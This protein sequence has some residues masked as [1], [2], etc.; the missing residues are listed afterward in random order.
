MF[1]SIV[2]TVLESTSLRNNAVDGPRVPCSP[3]AQV[4]GCNT[5]VLLIT[6]SRQSI[7]CGTLRARL[8]QRRTMWLRE[9]P[10]LTKDEM[11]S[12]TWRDAETGRPNLEARGTTQIDSSEIAI[13]GESRV[14]LESNR[15]QRFRLRCA[16]HTSVSFWLQ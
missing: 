3:A 5:L 4:P 12:V 9:R 6:C 13:N 16:R 1:R 11:S 10:H 14:N 2:L 15:H 7:D 8:G